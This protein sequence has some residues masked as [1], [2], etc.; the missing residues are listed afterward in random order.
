MRPRQPHL[1][2]P[3]T[4]VFSLQR[5][6]SQQLPNRD[7]IVHPVRITFRQFEIASNALANSLL[8]L[9]VERGDRV[10]LFLK[11]S[12]ESE[13]AWYGVNKTGATVSIINPFHQEMEVEYQVRDSK[14][15]AI[16]VDEELYPLVKRIRKR[17]RLR[18]IVVVGEPEQT[19]YS[20]DELVSR[21]SAKPPDI[22]IDP[23]KDIASLW[24]TSGTTAEPKGVM[25]THYNIVASTLQ[26]TVA[27]NAQRDDIALIVRDIYE[28]E[29]NVCLYVGIPQ[30][31]LKAFDAD[32][33]EEFLSLVEQHGVTYVL[34]SPPIIMALIK[35]IE[36][37]PKK[38]DLSSLKFVHNGSA[39]ISPLVARKFMKLTGVPVTQGLGLAEATAVTANPLF[40]V[41]I[42]SVGI[43]VSDTCVKLVDFNT[44]QE[45]R[46][47]QNGE[48]I[49]KGPQVMKGYWN[50]PK[51]TKDALV[52][53]KGK[54]WLRTG[55]LARMDEQG[56]LYFV[57]RV[58]QIIKY[59]GFS[60]SPAELEMLLLRHPA[61][62]DC[63]VV[64]K[65]VNGPE[66]EIPKA[67]VQLKQ[68]TKVRETEIADFVSKRVARY[69]RIREVEFV[70][71]LSRDRLGKARHRDLRSS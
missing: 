33:S 3:K 39:P 15:D 11:K 16:I 63:L 1:Y 57:S 60:V 48:L 42:E 22:S 20:F 44:M 49:V 61:I 8:S 65:A 62:A 45:V 31:I 56:Y 2:Y 58:K 24:Y 18:I 21:T 50:R 67:F 32:M 69:K 52:L 23:E 47:G 40:K 51:D 36:K 54:K 26:T 35:Q 43:P 66:G 53:W 70:A 7:A 55:D 17:I 37:L 41:K 13:L 25:L 14:A 6:T 71:Y 34:V 29:M 10:C 38:Y 19:T 46:K 12:P 27:L 28:R 59:K 4:P 64:G 68:G 9:G 30:V 5:E